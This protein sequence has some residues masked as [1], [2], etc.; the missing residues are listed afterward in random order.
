MVLDG[1]CGQVVVLDIDVGWQVG[2]G[3]WQVEYGLVL[4]VVVGW[5]IWVIYGYGEVF[6]VGWGVGLG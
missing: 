3:G 2:G 5:G 6:G 4:L 1:I